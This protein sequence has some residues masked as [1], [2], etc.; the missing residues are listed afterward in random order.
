MQIESLILFRS[1]TVLA[2]VWTEVHLGRSSVNEMEGPGDP[3]VP[4]GDGKW[5]IAEM[6]PASICPTRAPIF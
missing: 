3:F 1:I 5:R 6:Y 4:I 2:W